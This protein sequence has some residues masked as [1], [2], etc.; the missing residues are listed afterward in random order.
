M[1]YISRVYGGPELT[2]SK[3]DQ[4]IAKFMKLRGAERDVG[5]FG[6]LDVVLH[7]PGSVFSPEPFGVRT[8]RFSKKERTLM[9]QIAVPPEVVEKDDHQIEA[10]LLSAL[11][12]AVRKGYAC[13]STGRHSL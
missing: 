3:I 12:E 7:V 1:M 6:S 5:Q 4:T 9:L 11:R 2:G 8:S 13:L 10:Y